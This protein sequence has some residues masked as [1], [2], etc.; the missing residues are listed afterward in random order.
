MLPYVNE[1]CGGG[2]LPVAADCRSFLHRPNYCSYGV[3]GCPWL[4]LSPLDFYSVLVVVLVLLWSVG[5]RLQIKVSGA[6]WSLGLLPRG[7]FDWSWAG[8]APHLLNKSIFI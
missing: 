2:L 6:T 4:V 8:R 1:T 3:V 7:S 5:M